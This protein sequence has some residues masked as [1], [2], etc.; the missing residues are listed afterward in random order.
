MLVISH[1]VVIYGVKKAGEKIKDIAFD[2]RK[3]EKVNVLERDG[4]IVVDFDGKRYDIGN[5]LGIMQA[6]VEIAL[7]HT[8]IGKDFKTY[9]KELCK[10]L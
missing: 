3:T 5:K 9:L 8:E 7:N 1:T 6:N 4:I 2:G 10:S